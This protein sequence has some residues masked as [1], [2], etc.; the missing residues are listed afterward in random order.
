MKHY[1]VPDILYRSLVSKEIL[2]INTTPTWTDQCIV[3]H[4]TC[5]KIQ[6]TNTTILYNRL[7]PLEI[8]CGFQF[9]SVR[10]L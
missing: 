6:L 3:I 9:L 7:I 4:V 1:S 2:F 10:Q 8:G 5:H